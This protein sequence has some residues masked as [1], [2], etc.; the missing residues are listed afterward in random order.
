MPHDC[1]QCPKALRRH[2]RPERLGADAAVI[3]CMLGGIEKFIPPELSSDTML[4]LSHLILVGWFVLAPA[5][6][7]G[8][9][10]A[11]A[12][13]ALEGHLHIVSLR[14]VE[15]ADGSAPTVT[16][17][18]YAEYPL[19]ILSQNRKKEIARVV[20]NGNGNYRVALPPGAYVLDVQDRVRKHVRAIPQPFTIV[21]SQ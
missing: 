3:W 5:G 9:E 13:G 17:E 21:S 15:P 11:A 8:P 10:K 4:F 20:A 7:A 2:A 6:C 18:T 19:V 1:A 14:T 12:T 16:P